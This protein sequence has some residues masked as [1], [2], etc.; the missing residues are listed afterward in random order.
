[1]KLSVYLFRQN[2]TFE[3]ALRAGLLEGD[4]PYIEIPAVKPLPF[5][6]RAYLRKSQGKLPRWVSFSSSYFDLSSLIEENHYASF[7]LLVETEGRL[8]AFTFGYAYAALDPAEIET[9]FGLRVALNSVDERRIKAVA[10]RQIDPVGRDQRVNLALA[11]E[12]SSFELNPTVDWIRYVAGQPRIPTLGKT[13]AGSNHIVVSG[14]WDIERL[15]SLCTELFTLY[16]STEYREHFAFIDY[17]RP[18][19]RFDP[20]IANL[21]AKVQEVIDDRSIT[22]V[23]LADPD[24]TDPEFLDH[25]VIWRRKNRQEIQDLL[26][27]DVYAFLDSLDESVSLDKIKLRPAD[28]EGRPLAPPRPLRQYLTYE[29]SI[30]GDTYVLCLGQW[31]R[32]ERDYLN[33]IRTEIS[34]LVTDRTNDFAL[35]PIRVGESERRYNARVANERGW[36]LLDRTS[37]AAGLGR[38]ERIEACDLLTPTLDFVCVKK[39]YSSATL[40]HLFAQARVSAICL[41][42]SDQYRSNLQ[43]IAAE[44]WPELSIDPE[45]ARYVYAIATEK[46]GDLYESLFFFSVIALLSEVRTIRAVGAEPSLCRI[47]YAPA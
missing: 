4:S 24:Y 33:R 39:A 18:I 44:K 3:T 27:T 17:L 11:S 16:N 29:V 12:F 37:V 8:F 22:K 23:C 6:C 31:F 1:V 32:V 26:L 35:P 46:E 41:R 28:E 2:T 21:E 38:H 30:N 13:I 45:R 9:G 36:L 47:G 34:Q 42:E 20:I 14:D 40:S 19:A 5:P 43:A 7:L 15:G 25:Y 10:A